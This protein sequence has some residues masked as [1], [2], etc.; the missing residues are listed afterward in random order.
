MT[1]N[2]AAREVQSAEGMLD[3]MRIYRKI[4]TAI[5]LSLTHSL[6]KVNDWTYYY[7]PLCI[8]ESSLGDHLLQNTMPN[9]YLMKTKIGFFDVQWRSTGRLVISTDSQMIPRLCRMSYLIMARSENVR[10]G[11][12]VSLAPFGIK[13]VFNGIYDSAVNRPLS[14][15]VVEYQSLMADILESFDY[16]LPQNAQWTQILVH[17]A[18]SPNTSTSLFLWPADLVFC[19][20]SL[21]FD[22]LDAKATLP[23]DDPLV[24]PLAWAQ[25]WYLGRHE[26][27]KAI[28]DQQQREDLEVKKT[29]AQKGS[30][31]VEEMSASE[32]VSPLN[33]YINPQDVSGV[34]P[35]PP[36]GF[37][38]QA[39][40]SSAND[41]VQ[42]TPQALETNASESI[43]GVHH[44]LQDNDNHDLFGDVDMD[45]FASNGVTDA[46]FSFF[47]E[48]DTDG[49]AQTVVE[50]ETPPS[51]T[52][53]ND[54]MDVRL[55]AERSDEV[56]TLE[57]GRDSQ[58]GKSCAHCL[59]WP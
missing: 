15:T 40:D 14:D 50:R 4:T 44:D 35:T 48:P 9:S 43:D 6:S 30:D 20:D 12:L 2:V 16:S 32:T 27:A 19:E 3:K 41:E 23:L 54:T 55:T 33:H 28:K 45:M 8:H 34:Y 52:E 10:I 21:E 58:P 47:D 25:A 38:S 11:A 46:D 51:T 26:R 31:D 13:G 39:N 59:K 24:D 57:E 1:S 29:K 37:P 53:T 5:A 7:G 42:I 22:F 18:A 36:D 56:G 17:S 49:E